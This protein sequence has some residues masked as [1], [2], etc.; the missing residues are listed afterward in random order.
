MVHASPPSLTNA[1][2][3]FWSSLYEG[4]TCISSQQSIR[5]T[6]RM[7]AFGNN[8]CCCCSS[9]ETIS[10]SNF[11]DS[12]N[13]T[14][15]FLRDEVILHNKKDD[16]WA[17]VNGKVIDISSLFC[18]FSI[19]VWNSLYPY[20][21]LKLKFELFCIFKKNSLKHLLIFAGKDL[22][23]FFHKT[24]GEPKTRITVNGTRIPLL[25]AA[26]VTTDSGN[27]YW[28]NDP[29]LVLG[30]I[31]AR[32]RKLRIINTL[33]TKTQLM[34]VCEED[35]L[36]VIRQKYYK[37]NWHLDGYH[38]NRFDSERGKYFGLCMDKTLTENGF[39][40]ENDYVPPSIWL[41]FKDDKS[42]A[43]W[44]FYISIQ[45]GNKL[46]RKW[47]LTSSHFS[48]LFI[49][50]IA[51]DDWNNSL[52]DRRACSLWEPMQLRA[53]ESKVFYADLQ[54]LHETMRKRR[55]KNVKCVNKQIE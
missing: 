46:K 14:T 52:T 16:A 18:E 22:S 33:T 48:C 10:S 28:W 19:K 17:I 43:W 42:V 8:K 1:C 7:S 12:K 51:H 20:A 15:F 47:R 27:Y 35:T 11:T 41:K 32:P 29:C 37:Y 54:Q 55:E 50:F 2:W 53:N 38:W 24:N 6:S 13:E 44:A 49:S 30:Q 34:T 45:I 39:L 3:R 23:H 9:D 26:F 4:E 5:L 21:S 36:Q 31:T 40:Y 25:P